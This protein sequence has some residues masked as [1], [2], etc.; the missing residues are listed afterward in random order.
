MALTSCADLPV[1]E[2]KCP[3]PEEEMDSA[4][5]ANEIQ[6]VQ[7][8]KNTYYYLPPAKLICEKDEEILKQKG[9]QI[10]RKLRYDTYYG[11]DRWQCQAQWKA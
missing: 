4:E 10:S 6:K 2:K 11:C 1:I 9:Y 7:E 5:L 3:P 8:Y